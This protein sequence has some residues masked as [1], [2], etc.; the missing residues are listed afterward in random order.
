VPHSWKLSII[1]QTI[2]RSY[3]VKCLRALVE[4]GHAVPLLYAR[5]LEEHI[6]VY[7]GSG[8]SLYAYREKMKQILYNSHERPSLLQ[9]H[10]PGLMVGLGDDEL[11]FRRPKSPQRAPLESD[12]GGTVERPSRPTGV[13]FLKCACGSTDISTTQ[14][15]TRSADEGFT[16]FCE[17]LECS[18]RWR[19]G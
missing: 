4:W 14:R 5:Y 9:K 7:S 1:Q 16:V 8:S 3:R 19:M 15:Q 13:A 2:S 6:F 11:L 17:C 10:D 12:G 18:R